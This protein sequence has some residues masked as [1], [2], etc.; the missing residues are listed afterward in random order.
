MLHFLIILLDVTNTI[1]CDIIC[2]LHIID[3]TF[4]N[5]MFLYRLHYIKHV[6]V[7]F[8]G[9]KHFPEQ[10]KEVDK[11]SVTGSIQ[12]IHVYMENNGPHNKR[13]LNIVHSNG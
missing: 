11:N 8:E 2:I 12:A 6:I 4:I 7:L 1:T 10:P 9:C 3:K 13:P 5:S